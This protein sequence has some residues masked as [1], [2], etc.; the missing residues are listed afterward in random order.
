VLCVPATL[1]T[2]PKAHAFNGSILT[3]ND[4]HWFD[5]ERFLQNGLSTIVP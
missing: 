4:R 3:L 1:H 5:M 2:V